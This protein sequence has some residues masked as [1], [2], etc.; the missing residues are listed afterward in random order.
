M[1]WVPLYPQTA[2]VTGLHNFYRLMSI[3]NGALFDYMAALPHL[4][5]PIQAKRRLEWA[6]RPPFPPLYCLS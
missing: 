3:I 4:E 2:V 6:T 1:K 5:L